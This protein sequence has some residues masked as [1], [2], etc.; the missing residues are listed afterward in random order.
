MLGEATSEAFG[1]TVVVD[2]GMGTGETTTVRV[3]S[4]APFGAAS[5]KVARTAAAAKTTSE[6]KPGIAVVH[7]DSSVKLPDPGTDVLQ[8]YSIAECWL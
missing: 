6:R 1:K 8:D 5:A 7:Q 4:E 3:T 2:D